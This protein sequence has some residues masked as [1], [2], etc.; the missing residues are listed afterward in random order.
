MSNKGVIR[1]VHPGGA[2]VRGDKGYE[3]LKAKIE[4][5]LKEK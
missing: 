4:E 1:H 2:Y 3:A 5:L